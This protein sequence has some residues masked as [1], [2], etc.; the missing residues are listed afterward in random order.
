MSTMRDAELIQRLHQQTTVI[1]EDLR[2]IRRHL[3]QFPELSG[4]E[5]HTTAYLIENL[6][7]LG[8][9]FKTNPGGHGFIADLIS[10][11]SKDTLAL[12]V[13]MDALP[14]HEVNQVPYRSKIPGVMH[15]CGHDVHSA[16]GIGVA[17]A[18]AGMK[19]N[20]PI[21][22]RFIFQPE[23]EEITGALNMIHAGALEDPVPK[24]IWGLHVAPFQSGKI[25]WTD[26]LFLSGFEHYLA[27]LSP[28]NEND[29]STGVLGQIAQDSSEAIL[30]LNHWHLPLTWKTMQAF[31]QT[32][33]HDPDELRQFII[34][35]A[36]T[37][38]EEPD[39]WEGQFGVGIKAATPHLY[40]EA[41]AQIQEI[42]D[43]KCD[44]S[45]LT[46]R[47]LPMG[48]MD[49]VHNNPILMATALPALERVIGEENLVKLNAAFP[50]NCEDFNYYTKYIP[51]AMIWLG[52]ADPAGGKYAML[53]TPTFD[54]DETCLLTG[55][56]A[57]AALLLGSNNFSQKNS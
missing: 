13:D 21:N 36:S 33:Q 32:M 40:Q 37:N 8:L 23:E 34:Y 7:G 11:P 27:V 2:L 15:A 47:L 29:L 6:Q 4:A 38:P 31:W 26:G 46:Y 24:A 48:A 25:A 39:L 20:L 45:A 55:T 52:A 57:M 18:L 56:I 42:L 35:D 14:I 54:V 28:Q 9:A 49:A 16:I 17:R 5:I 50:F 30:A 53:H 19:E 3:H 43:T 10:D 51:G 41:L 44:S 22:I 12:R 1:Y